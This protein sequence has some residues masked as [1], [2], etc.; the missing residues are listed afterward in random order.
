VS[1]HTQQWAQM[2]TD[3]CLCCR[4][5]RFSSGNRMA[6]QTVHCQFEEHTEYT[7]LLLPKVG[8]LKIDSVEGYMPW[9]HTKAHLPHWSSGG[10][11]VRR[12]CYTHW[13]SWGKAVSSTCRRL[14]ISKARCPPNEG[15]KSCYVQLQPPPRKSP[16]CTI[17]H[18]SLRKR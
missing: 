7:M 12:H 5:S 3:Q 17:T 18:T 1:P 13:G 14:H 2:G 11:E 4:N 10:V 9:G 15:Q 6:E 16:K 8:V